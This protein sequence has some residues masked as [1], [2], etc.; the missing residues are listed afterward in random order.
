MTDD[1]GATVASRQVDG[2]ECLGKRPNLVYLYQDTVGRAVLD[3]PLQALHIGD[4]E[5]VPDQLNFAP[6]LA[7]QLA[8][9]I[10]VILGEAI[11]DGSNRVLGTQ[12]LPEVNHFIGRGDAVGLALEKAVA[13]FALF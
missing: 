13:G 2:I 1:G 4:K 11:F 8:P 7:R 6:Q 5:V 12:L 10:P 3:A 9:T